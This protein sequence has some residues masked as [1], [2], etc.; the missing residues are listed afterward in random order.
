VHLRL[1]RLEL[2]LQVIDRSLALSGHQPITLNNRGIALW[3]LGRHEEALLS[4]ERAI[5]VKADYVDA[6]KNRGDILKILGKVEE[7]VR[8]YDGAIALDPGHADA[9]KNRGDALQILGKP[10]EALRCYDKVIALKPRFADAFNQRGDVLCHLDRTVEALQS[11]TQ[12]ITLKPDYAPAFNN[13]GKALVTLNRKKDA[14]TNFERALALQPDLVEALVN[15]GNVLFAMERPVDALQSF[16]T[17][18]ALRPDVAY[19]RGV[20]LFLRALLCDMSERTGQTEEVIRRIE[21]GERVITPGHML[22][23][24]ST[25]GLQHRCAKI[26]VRDKF[27]SCEVV[28]GGKTEKGGDRIRLGYFSADFQEHAT[29]YLTAELFELHDR[30]KFEIIAYRFGSAGSDAMRERLSA[31]FD[32]FEDVSELSD[33]Q[34]AMLARTHAIDI[35]IDLNGYTRESRPGIFARRAAP[36]QVNFLAFPGTMGA[37]FIDY[38]IADPIVIPEH[39]R[40]HYSEKIVYLPD[41]Y[42]VNDRKREIAPRVNTRAELGL[43]DSGFVFCSFNNSFKFTPDVFAV[44]MR[45]LGRIPDSVLWLLAD[46]PVVRRN[47][48]AEAQRLGVDPSRLCFAQRLDLAAHLARHRAADLFLDTFVCNAH[49]TASDALWVGL[50][51][52]TCM[53]ETFAARVAASL[54]TAIGLPEL[55]TRSPA[56]YEALAVELASRPEQLQ[57]IRRK[58]AGNR[59]T[60]PLFDSPRYT[61]NIEAAYSRMWQRYQQGLE[62]QHI[63]I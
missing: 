31:A 46:H 9:W 56:E 50:P 20:M 11:Y 4:F 38:I 53:G 48:R 19:L 61:R 13:R 43:P 44:W 54:L 49:T 2:G 6:W 14:L 7:A 57:A 10:E 40:T 39:H 41:C 22:H 30:K 24:P 63:C 3:H 29:A 18:F 25:P 62:P 28:P 15:R 42:Q 26:Y 5:E 37:A 1:G 58:L 60:H 47:L 27:H 55:I 59:L 33:E 8:S 23:L 12:A 35:A 32:R 17:A 45:I 52:L 34:A 51:V 36:I 16:E 21:N